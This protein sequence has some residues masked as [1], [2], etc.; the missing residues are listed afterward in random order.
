[1][2]LVAVL[3]CGCLSVKGRRAERCG[4]ACACAEGCGCGSCC[5]EAAVAHRCRG[6]GG[7]S[8]RVCGWRRRV[9]DGHVRACGGRGGGARARAQREGATL[10]QVRR[11]CQDGAK[12]GVAMCLLTRCCV[13]RRPLLC[14]SVCRLVV[15]DGAEDAHHPPAAPRLRARD[16]IARA[17]QSAT[18]QRDAGEC[19]EVDAARAAAGGAVRVQPLPQRSAAGGATLLQAPSL[20]RRAS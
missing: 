7:H 4:L 17:A 13:T 15:V 3:P 18:G 19:G 12:R 10:G 8:T 9:G 16:G 20:C 1:M 14:V 11:A 6:G 5:C 2:F